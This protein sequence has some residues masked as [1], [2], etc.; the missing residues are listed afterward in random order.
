MS[1]TLSGTN[2][3]PCS[4]VTPVAETLG[5]HLSLQGALA[6]PLTNDIVC[7]PT[8]DQNDQVVNVVE[9]DLIP[10]TPSHIT[11]PSIPISDIDIAPLSPFTDSDVELSGDDLF[12]L[13]IYDGEN[14]ALPAP[15]YCNGWEAVP[16]LPTRIDWSLCTLVLRGPHQCDFLSAHQTAPASQPP[17]S[18]APNTSAMTIH[19]L[20]TANNKFI[21][22]F[23]MIPDK[24]GHTNAMSP[25]MV[26]E[27][28]VV[29]S[30]EAPRMVAYFIPPDNRMPHNID[31]PWT[32]QDTLAIRLF[33]SPG[34][35][36]VPI[37]V[38]DWGYEASAFERDRSRVARLDRDI[39]FLEEHINHS[40]AGFDLLVARYYRAVA[41]GAVERPAASKDLQ[42]AGAWS[43][44][45]PR[46]ARLPLHAWKQRYRD[47]HT[48]RFQWFH[49]QLRRVPILAAWLN[50]DLAREAMLTQNIMNV[51]IDVTRRHDNSLW[52]MPLMAVVGVA[53]YSLAETRPFSMYC[54]LAARINTL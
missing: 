7:P 24:T 19:E 13:G 34:H 40:N 26:W 41:S 39:G 9:E 31:A 48:L 10:G 15:V 14:I 44:F 6:N 5:S 43:C 32:P 22:A 42:S 20:Q 53:A 28:M 3:L 16:N 1:P 11:I 25:M 4:P 46:D 12:D 50:S 51:D 36:T 37:A 35:T 54:Y 27:P 2:E 49:T 23:D 8:D 30:P 38:A 29:S 18:G 17:I 52:W 47:L 33:T 21:D 45:G